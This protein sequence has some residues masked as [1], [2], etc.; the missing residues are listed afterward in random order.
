MCCAMCVCVLSNGKHFTDEYVIIYVSRSLSLCVDVSSPFSFYLTVTVSER[1]R[2]TA[3]LRF[4]PIFSVVVSCSGRDREAEEQ[5]VLVVR[6]QRV[7]MPNTA[8]AR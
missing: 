2:R 6:M 8:N 7:P 1:N 3:N 4:P 5:S